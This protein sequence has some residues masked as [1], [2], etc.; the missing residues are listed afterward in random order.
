MTPHL[1][2]TIEWNGRT[3]AW[4]RFGDGPPLVFLHGTPWSSALWRPIAQA[5]SSRFT[6]YL[7]DM[8]GYGVSS[9]HPDHAVDLGVQGEL[10]AQLLRE[11]GLERP[12]VIAHD[13][14]G[15]VSLR[16]RLLHGARFASLCLV[17]VVALRPWGSPFFRL[18]KQHAEV[19]EQLPPAVHRGA[20]EAYISGASHRGLRPED[21]AMLVEPWTGGEGPAA[22]YR[23]MA[24]ADERFTDEVEPLYGTID[25]PTHIVWG[26]EDEWIAVDR[27][28]RL[29][30]LIPG[31]SLTLVEGAGH[32]IQLDAPAQLTAE[33]TRWTESQRAASGR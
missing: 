10:F 12:H 2:R 13:F 16:A 14:G 18:V 19:F 11:W 31:A 20:V 3:V 9:K 24:Q 6:V 8:P 22:L 1:T 28:H 7:W 4:N 27:A 21:L 25:E 33:L 32:L 17:D 5:L 26:A 23:Q 30:S 15:V 29:Q